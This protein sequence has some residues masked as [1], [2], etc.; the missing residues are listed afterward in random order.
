MTVNKSIQDLVNENKRL[1]AE[2]KA[3]N[4]DNAR[5]DAELASLRGKQIVTDT[6]QA[7]APKPK[8]QIGDNVLVAFYGIDKTVQYQARIVE[9]VKKEKYGEPIDAYRMWF[10]KEEKAS[11]ALFEESRIKINPYLPSDD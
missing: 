4:E 2:Y 9:I 7:I 5:L 11:E 10:D 3:L 1:L 8:F 6:P